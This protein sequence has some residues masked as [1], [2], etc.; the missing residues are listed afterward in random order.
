MPWQKKEPMDLRIEFAMK[1]MRA[2]N[3]RAL[4]AEYGIST[5]T[6]YKWQRRFLEHGFEGMAEQSRRPHGH[7]DQLSEAEV[8]EIVRFK[9]AHRH[10]GPKKIREL[11]V[12]KHGTAASESSFKRVLA[13][14][15]LTEPRRRRQRSTEAGRLWTGRRGRVPNEVWTVDFKGWWYDGQ[16]KRCEPLTVR[17]EHSRYILELRRMSDGRTDTVRACFE[18][19]FELHGLPEAIRSDNGSPF[20]QVRGILGLSR[21]SAWWVALGIDLERGRPGH[22]QDNGGHERMHRDIRVELE[23]STAEQA[24]LD[25]WRQEFN[26]ERPHEALGMRCPAQVYSRSERQYEGSPEDLEYPAMASRKVSQ[27]GDI[28]WEASDYFIGTSLAG[29]SVGLKALADGTFEVWFGRL[30]LGWIDPATESFGRADIRPPE[31]GQ[32]K[33]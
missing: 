33:P 12:R 24:A 7:A 13:R 9:N 11:Y 6:G 25:M 8:C 29:W 16:G 31:A 5:K 23:P 17:D 20:A 14:A 26:C 15:G 18:R 32:P 4:C 22:P 30:L 19:L 10:W 21:L 2:D 27:D 3:F 28:K 1:A